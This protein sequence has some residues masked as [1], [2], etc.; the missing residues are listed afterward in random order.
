VN[1]AALIVEDQLGRADPDSLSHGLRPAELR[2]YLLDL[3]LTAERLAFEVQR[4]I[5]S[6]SVTPEARQ[7]LGWRL[8]EL[9]REFRHAGGRAPL[10]SVPASPAIES[11]LRQLRVLLARPPQP[12]A[13]AEDAQEEPPEEQAPERGAEPEPSKLHPTT[14]QAIQATVACGLALFTGHRVS[15][16]RWYWAVIAAFVIFNRAS[17]QG[18]ILLRAWHRILGTVIGVVAGILLATTVSGH[19]D[20]EFSLIFVCIFLG[21]YLIRVSYAWMVF[22]FTALLSVLYSL[23]GRYSPGLLVLRVEETLIGAGIG[24]VV[25]VVLLP[26]RTGPRVQRAAIDTLHSVAS[27]L[28]A[29]AVLPGPVAVERVREIDA[30]LREVRDAARPLTARKFLTDRN[31]L[32]LVHALSGLSFFVRQLA[33]ACTRPLGDVE[34]VRSLERELASNARAVAASLEGESTGK[35]WALNGAIQSVRESLPQDASRASR[36]SSRVL[37]WLERIDDALLEVYDSLRGFRARRG[38]M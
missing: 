29:A 21:F 5:E 1:E 34:E 26:S 4:F 38:A 12:R 30:K 20:L 13:E 36:S 7:A 31:A 22:F 32:R 2:E 3:E 8:A 10:Q 14:R 16:S 9:R 35:P 19:R 33:S 15:S 23:L 17:T 27:F 28:E 18:D 37:H 25:A 11:A 6:A 24:A